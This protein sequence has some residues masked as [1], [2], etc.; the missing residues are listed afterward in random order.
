MRTAIRSVVSLGAAISLSLASPASGDQAVDAYS[1]EQRGPFTS[2]DAAGRIA[3]FDLDED[4]GDVGTS[5]QARREMMERALREAA[6][7]SP[8]SDAYL[9][10][11]REAVAVGFIYVWWLLDSGGEQQGL[12]A[13]ETLER[14][15]NRRA[16][17]SVPPELRLAAGRL[18][19]VRSRIHLE[20]GDSEAAR[21]ASDRVLDLSR[22]VEANEDD[23]QG[24]LNL[25]A[26][27]LLGRAAETG[28][29][30]GEAMRAEAC[31]LARRSHDDILPSNPNV[32]RL[33]DC[34]LGALDEEIRRGDRS[35]VEARLARVGALIADRLQ[36]NPASITMRMRNVELELRKSEL[37]FSR[38]VEA[39]R[40]KRRVLEMLASILSG[41]EYFQARVNEVQDYYARASTLDISVLPEFA[42]PVAA[43][44]ENIRLF[45]LISDA[46]EHTRQ[47]FPGAPSFAFASADAA[48]R[49][50]NLYFAAGDLPAAERAS[51]R[52]LDA[53]AV[54]RP[55]A[56]A[57]EYEERPERHCYS[58]SARIR[59]LVEME[60]TDEALAAYRDLERTCGEWIRRYPWDFYTRQ[61]LV[62]SA[63]RV[64]P[65]LHEQ[66]RYADALPILQF[67]SDWGINEGSL[68][69]ADIY[70][71][72]R[73][74]APDENRADELTALTGRQ[75]MKRFTVQLSHQGDSFP[76]FVYV[77]EFARRPYCPIRAEPLPVDMGCAGFEGIDDQ[78]EWLR[79]A[80]GLE[81]PQ[82]I[83]ESFRTVNRDA[84]THNLPFP[85]L[86]VERL[87]VVETG[88]AAAPPSEPAARGSGGNEQDS[89]QAPAPR[90]AASGSAW[91]LITT[92]S[93][94]LF[95][96]DRRSDPPAVR[97]DLVI[98]LRPGVSCIAWRVEVER[99]PIDL[100]LV[101]ELILPAPAARSDQGRTQSAAPEGGGRITTRV[102]ESASD[103]LLANRRCLRAGDPTGVYRLRVQHGDRLIGQLRFQV[104]PASDFRDRRLRA[105]D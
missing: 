34:E 72:G 48:A 4:A 66:R 88:A 95:F 32:G 31:R 14:A 89:S 26:S 1:P 64:G 30:A 40:S 27:A 67:A 55:I 29:A 43:R 18:A 49:L 80:R 79:R 11:I 101:E 102:V 65:L 104:L 96:E 71:N 5:M 70:R 63:M 42:D 68:Y 57:L 100:E 53:F 51:A 47:R 105:A 93:I 94:R 3:M 10:A 78:A 46:L 13:L 45:R 98:P 20:R 37:A 41:R 17:A 50:S 82:A 77:M 44:N 58:F 56:R 12:E 19:W 15:L 60:R 99:G 97:E 25:R 81:V 103:G 69:L 35:R 84:R 6:Q 87:G 28:G 23:L 73:G 2:D 8:E 83:V 9:R 24:L 86:A 90:R 21:A 92:G 33:I 38:P 62:G 22:D 91:R 85:A 59:L 54:A 61:H 7:A 39:A 75:S 52:A 74:V 76:F 16:G 36:I